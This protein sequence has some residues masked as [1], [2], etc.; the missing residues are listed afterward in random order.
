MCK[1]ALLGEPFLPL[2]LPIR[3]AGPIE[4]LRV[5]PALTRVALPTPPL[6]ASLAIALRSTEADAL[7]SL[8]AP[9]LRPLAETALRL[10][11]APLVEVLPV[12]EFSRIVDT[13]SGAAVDV[14][15]VTLR[16]RLGFAAVVADDGA[17]GFSV[18][19]VD[20]SLGAGLEDERTLEL[21][22][23]VVCSLLLIDSPVENELSVKGEPSSRGIVR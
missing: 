11:D 16:W 10:L 7:L 19:A 6:V 21:C 23:E 22:T 5:R 12:R 15:T 8:L 17:L 20:E 1:G 18:G 9:S 14:F 4:V 3:A 2:L 13:D